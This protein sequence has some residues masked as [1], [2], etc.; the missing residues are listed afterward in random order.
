MD[1]YSVINRG[2]ELV[3]RISQC[4]EFDACSAALSDLG[5]VYFRGVF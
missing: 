4:G 3:V 1:F 5:V 2:D